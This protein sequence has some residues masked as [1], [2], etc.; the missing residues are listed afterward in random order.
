M[1]KHEK[2]ALPLWSLQSKVEDKGYIKLR[3]CYQGE[4]Q[5]SLGLY[6]AYLSK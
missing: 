4:I 5:D 3:Y 6:K 2:W 1:V